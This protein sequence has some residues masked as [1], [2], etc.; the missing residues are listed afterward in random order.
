MHDRHRGRRVR[1]RLPQ[2]RH[3]RRHGGFPQTAGAYDA[4]PNGYDMFLQKF[5]AAGTR[6]YGTFFGGTGGESYSS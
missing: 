5:D 1:Q 3:Q 2:R 4:T 6:V